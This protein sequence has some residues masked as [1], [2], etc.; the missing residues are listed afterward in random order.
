MLELMLFQKQEQQM[1]INI[2]LA[3]I[4]NASQDAISLIAQTPVKGIQTCWCHISIQLVVLLYAYETH[5]FYWIS[6]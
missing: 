5:S 4:L 3:S 1:I 2:L 6:N